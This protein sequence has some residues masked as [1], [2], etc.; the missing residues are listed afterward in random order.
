[1]GIK[2][3]LRPQQFYHAGTAPPSFEIPGS[4]TDMY[5][6]ISSTLAE[7][8]D[9]L[10]L[11]IKEPCFY[12]KKTPVCLPSDVDFRNWSAVLTNWQ[13]MGDTAK[14]TVKVLNEQPIAGKRD[15]KALDLANKLQ[16]TMLSITGECIE[17]DRGIDYDKLK[18]SA[19]YKEYKSET[20]F[21]QTVSLD[22]LMC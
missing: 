12:F 6:R 21:L 13:K 11:I 18:S 14:P 19:S 15:L 20:L 8:F 9:H 10:L 5:Y 2:T 22:E 7:C 1:M 4:A 17:E 16:K 3:N